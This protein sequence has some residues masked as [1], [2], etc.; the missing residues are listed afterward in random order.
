MRAGRRD[1]SHRRHSHR[2][3]CARR[4]MAPR[5]RL[6][7]RSFFPGHLQTIYRGGE[8]MKQRWKLL[9]VGSL[10]LTLLSFSDRAFACTCARPPLP[11]EAYWQAEAVF[12][13][14]V[15]GLS[16]IEEEDKI[17]NTV[18]KR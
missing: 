4:A 17:E 16:W 12:I 14:T 13:G 5:N 10:V 6:G 18:I 2:S 1:R 15:K 7:E 8:T 11:C 9:G 3:V